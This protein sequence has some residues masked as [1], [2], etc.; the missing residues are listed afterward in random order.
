MSAHLVVVGTQWG[1]EGKG[2]VVDHF[3]P[4]YDLVGRYQGGTNA[5]HTIVVQGEEYKMHLLPAG[6]LHKGMT[7]LIGDRVIVDPLIL[8]EEMEALD[9]AGVLVGELK[10]GNRVNLI[11]PWHKLRDGIAGGKIGTTKRGIGPTYTDLTNRRGIRVHDWLDE[12]RFL[13]RVEEEVAWNEELIPA[14]MRL[15]DMDDSALEEMYES[16]VLE[17]DAVVADYLDALE[18][19][20]K[21]GVEFIDCPWF[22]DKQS[23]AG[24]RM[25]FEG[26]QG[27]L[28]DIVYGSYPYVTSS[29]P[30]A[31]GLQVGTG[32]RA[33]DL[34]VL[35][36]VKAYTTRVGHGPFPTELTSETGE[37]LREI[38]KEYGATTGRPRR[39]GWL[40]LAILK[41]AVRVNGL[42][43]LALTKLDILSEFET[44]PVGV[45]YELSGKAI[46]E[47]PASL[48]VLEKVEPVYEEFAGWQEDITGVREYAKLPKAARE[49]VEFVEE[50]IGVPV[51]L[52]GVGPGRE[53]VIER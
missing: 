41:H 51:E 34:K 26:A 1:D 38:G 43:A 23:R 49:Y 21:F 22:L 28:L 2:K 4:E 7:C 46:S 20:Q 29:H 11:M 9:E 50:Q 40:D 10:I 6:M 39:C 31:S 48:Q 30:I 32:F 3:T 14:L 8:V 44:I 15:H 33:R 52:I 16:E 17:P 19:L 13:E 27:M 12:K 47:F 24:K 18:T 45:S 37:K 42:D 53:E 5:G 35:G 25:L 36:V